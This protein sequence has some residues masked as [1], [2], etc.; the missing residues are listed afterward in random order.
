[1]KLILKEYENHDEYGTWGE[2][3][4]GKEHGTFGRSLNGMWAQLDGTVF[5]GLQTYHQDMNG[6]FKQSIMSW[7]RRNAKWKRF[8]K[9]MEAK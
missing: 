8:L 4:Y 1:M 9:S 2:W 5:A 6:V 7:R 3:K